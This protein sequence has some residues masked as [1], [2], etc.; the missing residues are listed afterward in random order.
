M[1]EPEDRAIKEMCTATTREICDVVGDNVRALAELWHDLGIDQEAMRS[2]LGRTKKHVVKL[3]I[4]MREDQQ[5]MKERILARISSYAIEVERLASEL[6]M[7]VTLPEGRTVVQQEDEMRAL[8]QRLREI[9]SSRKRELRML[10]SEEADLCQ[11][12]QEPAFAFGNGG[13]I[14]SQEEL[15][16]LREHLHTLEQ[17]KVL[18]TC[19]FVAL[20]REVVAQLQLIGAEP[21]TEFER[22]IVDS[23]D[24]VILSLQNLESAAIYLHKLKEL[25]IARREEISA[26]K[27]QVN[28]YWERLNVPEEQQFRHASGLIPEAIARLKQ[29]L[30]R[31]KDLKRQR[32]REF[33]ERTNDEL[34]AWRRKC[35]VP[36][37]LEQDDP[38]DVSE[39]HLEQ[40]EQELKMYKDLY[41]ENK[42]IFAKVERR[43]ALWAKFLEMEKKSN[44]PSRLNNRGGQLLLETKERSRLQAEL[45][46]LEQEICSYIKNY[47][48]SKQEVFN[49][50]GD[51][52]L[53]HIAAQNEAYCLQKEQERLERESRRK[54]ARPPS[55]GCLKEGCP[56]TPS[57]TASTKMSRL[58]AGSSSCSSLATPGRATLTKQFS[59]RQTPRR[60]GGASTSARNIAN[61]RRSLKRSAQKK[62]AASRQLLQAEPGPSS[63]QHCPTVALVSGSSSMDSFTAF[64]A[65]ASNKPITSTVLAETPKSTPQG[66]AQQ[67][68]STDLAP[69]EEKQ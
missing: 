62:A 14:P 25:E 8:A 16:E 28:L 20:Q 3:F 34:I 32:L 4:A 50:W 26:L 37:T 22:Q 57:R 2:R 13:A 67:L 45:P 30:A 46:R 36:E 56:V 1:E 17:E 19:K 7:P 64:L 63:G 31:L 61:R 43:E 53:G 60:A 18:R 47:R 40:M 39:E 66:P 29:E 49:K 38:E 55:R 58:V 21:E 35:C 23:P 6:G 5:E 48:G 42:T 41:A 59:T 65:S 27:E 33:V 44:D 15:H 51:K 69:F 54:A 9:R 12:L 24:E 52:F 68:D 10:R 11:R